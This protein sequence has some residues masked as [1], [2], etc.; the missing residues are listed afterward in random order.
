MS[1]TAYMRG[2][3]VSEKLVWKLGHDTCRRSHNASPASWL[4]QNF[5]SDIRSAQNKEQEQ[6]RVEK[7]LAKIRQRFS[8]DKSLS[9]KSPSLCCTI[10]HDPFGFVMQQNPQTG[11]L[12]S[13]AL[14]FPP[15]SGYDRRKYVWKLLYIYMLGYDIEFGHKQARALTPQS[16][17]S[18][19]C[20]SLSGHSEHLMLALSLSQP[21]LFACIQLE[22]MGILPGTLT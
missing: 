5:I 12:K 3:Q 20:L 1:K 17:K 22:R 19:P 10:M 18:T 11:V 15:R 6:K 21:L 4:L 13:P 2:L 7:E 9:G 14:N 8:D 16:N